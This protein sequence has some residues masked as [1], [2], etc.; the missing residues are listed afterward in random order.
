MLQAIE[1]RDGIIGGSLYDWATS[2]PQQWAA[3][4][5]LR[6]LNPAGADDA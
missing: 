6:D 2:S 5:P 4:S 1:A 3:L